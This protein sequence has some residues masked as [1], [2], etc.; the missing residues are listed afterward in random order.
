MIESK[1]EKEIKYGLIPMETWKTEKPLDIFQKMADGIY[2]APPISELF[3]FG[4]SKV[5]HGRIVFE[6]TAKSN[7]YNPM[8]TTHGGFIATLLIRQWRVRCSQRS[9]QGKVRRVLN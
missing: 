2:P 1:L 4:I 5:E 8:G 3:E 6:G 9:T 7:F